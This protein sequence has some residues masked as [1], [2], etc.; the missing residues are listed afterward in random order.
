MSRAAALIERLRRQGFGE[1]EVYTK[2]GRSRAARL[3][4][5]ELS[6]A[7]RREE[8]W[9]VRAGNEEGSFFACATGPCPRTLGP[10]PWPRPSGPPLAL[11]PAT[12]PAARPSATDAPLFG[13]GEAFAILDTVRG[14]L[15]AE[16]PEARLL[17]AEVEDGYAEI[18]IES[19]RGLV[20]RHSVRL[21][22]IRLGARLGGR[23]VEIDAAERHARRLAPQAVARRLADRLLLAAAEGLDERV[24]DPL[25]LAPE[26][27]S[28][29]L[30]GLDP[31]WIGPEARARAAR[32]LGES[33]SLGSERVTV[34]DDGGLDTGVL[35]APC[36]GEGVA[37]GR[38]VLV[39]G[40]VLRQP[41]LCWDDEADGEKSG[42]RMR[43]SWRQPPR[44]GAT[45]LFL[46][47]DPRR[48]ANQL[49]TGLERGFYLVDVVAPVTVDLDANRLELSA[50]GF[51]I[52]SGRARRRVSRARLVTTITS[53]FG[54]VE[55][56]ARDLRFRIARASYGAPTLLVTG[57][58]LEP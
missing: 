3:E 35:A 54:G 21:A 11:P 39:E 53:F 47:P 43:P 14:E 4:A 19:S 41:L 56:V 1:V 17:L 37:T 8:G 15:A 10:F 29:V 23:A 16:A 57:L 2:T 5:G 45:H 30:A 26:V 31:L 27:G 46:E 6:C 9:A 58:E 48:P 28:A 32:L 18:A 34:I 40:G 50:C 25:V 49:I 55:G 42:C 44:R 13:E 33:R 51:E 52:R 12:E 38:V 24:R 20:S 22:S 36:D 7:L